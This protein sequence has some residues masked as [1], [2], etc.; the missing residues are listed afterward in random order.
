MSSSWLEGRGPVKVTRV[1]RGVL[2]GS[3]ADMVAYCLPPRRPLDRPIDPWSVLDLWDRQ[4][5]GLLSRD[6]VTGV[7]TVRE[8]AFR[9]WARR[10]A[11]RFALSTRMARFEEDSIAFLERCSAGGY[12]P[13]SPQ[14]QLRDLAVL[15]AEEAAAI[16][17]HHAESAEWTPT[18]DDWRQLDAD[19]RRIFQE[20]NQ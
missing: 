4:R 14:E 17:A 1:R 20:D 7:V 3:L 15:D 5:P 19:M 8:R 16:Q 13:P 12:L 10:N 6:A 18:P 11:A 9:A 2:S